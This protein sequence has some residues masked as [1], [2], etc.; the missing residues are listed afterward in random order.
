MEEPCKSGCACKGESGCL[1]DRCKC[2][3]NGDPCSSACGCSV[4]R[5]TR[6]WNLSHASGDPDKGCRCSAGSGCKTN[7]CRCVSERN[8][9][10]DGCSCS[11]DKCARRY[12]SLP[13]VGDLDQQSGSKCSAQLGCETMRRDRGCAAVT[14]DVSDSSGGCLDQKCKQRY[15]LR[16][17]VSGLTDRIWRYRGD[18]DA[19]TKRSKADSEGDRMENDHVWEIQIL[20]AVQG[21]LPPACNTRAV[22]DNLKV[23]ANHV[24]NLN[25]TTQK[26]NQAKKGPFTIWRN[27]YSVGRPI[28]LD[29]AIGL[30][31]SRYGKTT[32]KDEGYWDNIKEEVVKTYDKVIGHLHDP[33]QVI[34]DG[35]KPSAN[36]SKVVTTYEDELHSRLTAMDIGYM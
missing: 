27:H 13:R 16:E 19:Y 22:T 30:T 14:R 3:L 36:M 26:I 31:S 6:R 24:S 15:S 4:Q 18:V 29:E 21:S 7:N 35:Y 20:E 11:I 5:C 9:C 23:I 32:M 28:P 8:P 17:S 1:T 25:V 2:V 33:A 10:G 34:G 12:N